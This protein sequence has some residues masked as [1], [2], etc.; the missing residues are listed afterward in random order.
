MLTDE[1]AG[2]L[3]NSAFPPLGNYYILDLDGETMVVIIR[4]GQDLLHGILLSA[5]TVNL[6]VLFGMALP[7]VMRIVQEAI[8]VTV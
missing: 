2:T 6:G 1:V 8:P 3:A 4:Y 7:K 5:K